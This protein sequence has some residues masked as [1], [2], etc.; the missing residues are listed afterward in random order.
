MIIYDGVSFPKEVRVLDIRRSILPS[1]S[2]STLSMEG[3]DGSI[4]YGKTSD[5]IEI[6]IDVIVT[7]SNPIEL[8][9]NIRDFAY[10]ID[11]KEPRPLILP[12]DPDKYIKTVLSGG[13]D[14]DTLY[15]AG[16]AT[17]V[18]FAPDPYFYAINDDVFRINE[19]GN[20]LLERKGNADSY[21]FIRI[22]GTSTT[23]SFTI[24]TVDNSITYTGPLKAGETLIIDSNLMTAKIVGK[25]G[26]TIRSAIPNLGNLDFPVLAPK[27]N[28]IALT[29]HGGA[30]LTQY[31]VV[32]N[33]RW[34]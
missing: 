18:M 8:R 20:F 22:E 26:D 17:L 28:I 13:T 31:T 12:D 11:A 5:S 21:P 9:K 19:T 33:S 34:K 16:Q 27:L 7:G 1:Q 4:F 15:N 3:R 29:T 32:S 23:G 2:L 10:L 6:E 14:L 24:A 30:K 25:N